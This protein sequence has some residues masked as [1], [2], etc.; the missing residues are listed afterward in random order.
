MSEHHDIKPDP[1][2]FVQ[3]S[4]LHSVH[5]VV[6]CVPEVEA[7]VEGPVALFLVQTSEGVSG[8]A[9][10]H[11]PVQVA[12][13]FDLDADDAPLYRHFRELFSGLSHNV[14][15]FEDRT[16]GVVFPLTAL[17][18]VAVHLREDVPPDVVESWK[19]DVVFDEDGEVLRCCQQSRSRRFCLDFDGT[20]CRN[21]AG[22]L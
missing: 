2:C 6:L 4:L 22:F 15:Q 11:E 21:L 10:P 3:H 16:Q 8:Q 1:E 12:V 5:H 19:S 14:S 17:Q 18:V 13:P 20:P 9:A 7:G